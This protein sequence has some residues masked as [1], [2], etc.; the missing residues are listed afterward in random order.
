MIKY[1]LKCEQHHRF[2]AWFRNSAGYDEQL[3]AGEIA[4]PECGTAKVEKAIMAPRLPGKANAQPAAA[5]RKELVKLREAVER[6]CDYVG[7][8]FA[9]EARKIHYGEAE[10]RSIYGETSREDAKELAEEGVAFARIP[11]VQKENA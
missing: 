4:C 1:D 11:W 2:E 6:D 3:A 9:E 5:I 8:G 10:A 7:P